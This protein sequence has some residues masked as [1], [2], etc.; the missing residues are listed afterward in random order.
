MTL[1]Q[2]NPENDTTRAEL[3]SEEFMQRYG[4]DPNEIQSTE[5]VDRVLDEL[6]AAFRKR[7]FE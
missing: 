2:G 4:F 7:N 3:S 5:D 1:E 6:E